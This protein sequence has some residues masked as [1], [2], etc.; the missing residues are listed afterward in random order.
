MDLTGAFP[1]G[2]PAGRCSAR[3]VPHA[4]L[5]VLGVYP[6]AFHVKWTRPDGRSVRALALRPEPYPF[7][8]GENQEATF[9]AISAAW[10]PDH[11]AVSPA[12]QFNGS[13]G[14]AVHR[15]VTNPLRVSWERVWLSDAVPFF[16]VHRG[17]GTQGAAMTDVY[18]PWAVSIGLAPH[19]LP[20]R[21]SADSLVAQAIS[22]EGARL[23][24]EIRE[25]EATTIV[26]LGNEA[27][28]VAGDL[29]TDHQLPLRLSLDHYGEPH[30][31][32]LDGVQLAVLP[33]VHPGQRSEQWRGAHRSWIAK[34]QPWAEIT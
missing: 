18:D 27:L 34:H 24:D 30:Q 16:H 17:K 6:S 28:R 11:G 29:L 12:E 26:T 21:P 13:S 31:A 33:L 4:D 23:R 25:S 7:W 14:R 8:R 20:T 2:A 3:R 32:R 10:N 22:E 9:T 19:D 15:D 5:F 1:F